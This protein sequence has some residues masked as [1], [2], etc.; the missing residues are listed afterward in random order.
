M[1]RHAEHEWQLQALQGRTPTSWHA[2][3]PSRP[4]RRRSRA[5]PC[6]LAVVAG[7]LIATGVLLVLHAPLTCY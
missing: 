2:P 4:A 5:L 6:V 7:A 3:A 1:T